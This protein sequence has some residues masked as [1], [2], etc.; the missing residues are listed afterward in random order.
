VHGLNLIGTEGRIPSEGTQTAQ[1]SARIA[2]LLAV[3]ASIS[4]LVGCGIGIVNIL[5]VSVTER[6]RADRARRVA[7]G[8]DFNDVQIRRQCVTL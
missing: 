7:R 5:L 8:C 6:T 4:L 2:L 1:S 3:V